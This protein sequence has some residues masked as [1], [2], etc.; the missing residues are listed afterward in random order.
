MGVFEFISGRKK[1][2][3]GELAKQRLKVALVQ[4]RVKVNPE[5]LELIKMD[6]LTVI[7]RRLEIDEQHMQISLAREHHLDKLQADVPIKRQKVSFEWDPPAHTTAANVLR[8]KVQVE[9][10]RDETP[11]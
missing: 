2:T 8:G 7:S 6:L 10:E 4:D 11:D 9:V 5:L 3:P 1:P